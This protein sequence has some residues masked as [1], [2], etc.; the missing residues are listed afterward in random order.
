MPAAK[1]RIPSSKIQDKAL[2][3]V[4]TYFDHYST[5]LQTYRK[6]WSELFRATY[7]FE[8][9][10]RGEG[11]SQIFWPMAYRETEKIATRLTPNNPKFV[12][13]LQVPIN[14]DAPEADMTKNMQA[15]QAAINYFW[16]LGNSQAKLRTWGKGGCVYGAMFAFVDFK[17]KMHKTKNIEYL[18]KD[19]EVIERIVE[20][21]EL[22]MEFPVFE[23]PD[24]L[25]LYFDP[26]I[27]FIDDMP[28]II[29]NYDQVRKSEILGQKEIYFN[30]DKVKNLS[31]QEF[32][33]TRDSYKLNKFN[34]EG[35]PNL[36]DTPDQSTINI[37]K[38]YGY[39]SETDKLE[40]EEMYK[41]TVA[42][43]SVVI[44]YESIN[45]LPV[46]KF[47]PIEVPNQGVGKGVVESIKKLQ[48][49]YN[50][51][52]NQRLENISLIINRMWK[53]KQGAGIDPRKLI[54]RAGNVI[55]LRDM[56][57][58]QPLEFPDLSQS[59]FAE[60]NA[61][62]TEI[63]AVNGTI[64]ATQDSSNNG[65]TNLATGQ[66]I[67]WN[68]FN[69]R[70]KSIKQN[71]EEAL[72]R[73]G[74]KMLMM[75]A[76]R[77]EANPLIKDEVTQKFYEVAKEAFNSFSDFYSISVLADSTSYDSIENQRDDALAKGN[78]GLSY[79]KA[80][81]AINTTELWKD[82]MGT[83]PGT[84]ANKYLMP[85]Q[86]QA[87][88]EQGGGPIP[89]NSVDQIKTQPTPEDQLNQSLTNV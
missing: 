43:D 11:K 27:E 14:P 45:F 6:T 81:V 78:L 62:N 9:E 49:A 30:L 84:D 44:G 55:S 25:D 16:K 65:F 64:D 36:N 89:Q 86:P 87:S 48:D 7:I 12:I 82:I 24:I 59:A 40:D 46:E 80:G 18:E 1:Q 50:L 57:A 71:L 70:F 52:R 47:V 79:Q 72:A 28:C 29:R 2:Q 38:Y 77:A 22:L 74:Q 10:R 60:A 73:L 54:S 67:R 34:S 61:L 88:P 76:E 31:A 69:T 17:R 21:D 75:V 26:R 63:Q 85:V 8:T 33:D 32:A 56:D 58:L 83:F 41:I 66:K 35:V 20:K 68:E 5:L 53:M 42:N 19:G 37:K 13:G 4:K 3:Q 39:F 15:N 51:T 23:V